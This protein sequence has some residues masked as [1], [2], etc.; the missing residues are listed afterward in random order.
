MDRSQ[1]LVRFYEA[2]AKLEKRLGEKRRLAICNHE[3]MWP[4]RGVYF[5]FETGEV[6]TNPDK[7][8][9][10]VRVGTHAIK[11][12]SSS[13]LWRRLS[14]HRGASRSGGGNHRGSIFRLLIGQAM[15]SRDRRGEPRSW[16][17]KGDHAKAA[18]ELGIEKRALKLQEL[19]LERHVSEY[20][21]AMPFLW[22]AIEDAPGPE[23]GRAAIERNSI[24]LLSNYRKPA[25][26]P[27]SPGWLGRSSDRERVR[28]SG[29]WNNKHVHEPY[30]PA[31]LTVLLQH[32]RRV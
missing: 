7:N 16:E 30:D 2:L 22:V 5:F 24:A 19:P 6:R 17:L 20:I 1:D 4:S 3:A 12:N 21:C 13:S 32:V 29:L 14:Q 8:P 27:P 25:I 11:A 18:A 23:S 10:V 31:F 9:R 15:M 28:E 26:D